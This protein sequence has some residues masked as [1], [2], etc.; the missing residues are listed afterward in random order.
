MGVFPVRVRVSPSARKKTT[1]FQPS[2]LLYND[3]EQRRFI[4]NM[5][6]IPQFYEKTVESIP[7][8]TY[9]CLKYRKHGEALHIV[10]FSSIQDRNDISEVSLLPDR[11]EVEACSHRRCPRRRQDHYGSTAD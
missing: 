11:L 2:F 4:H 7:Q 9:L 10:S 5:E 3:K 8:F 1:E 6:S